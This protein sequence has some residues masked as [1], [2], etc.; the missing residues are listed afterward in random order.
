[1]VQSWKQEKLSLPTSLELQCRCQMC[2]GAR[3]R[4]CCQP[5]DLGIL[6]QQRAPACQQLRSE[7]ANK[8]S[9]APLLTA[10]PGKEG[11]FILLCQA[12]VRRGLALREMRWELCNNVWVTRRKLHACS[13]ARELCPQVLRVLLCSPRLPQHGWRSRQQHEVAGI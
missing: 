6:G 13:V 5:A 12:N 3:P 1:M 11:S 4:C 8:A 9:V 10:R 2:V 7:K